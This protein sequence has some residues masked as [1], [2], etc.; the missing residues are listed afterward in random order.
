MT[1]GAASRVRVY[2]A[3]IGGAWA[4]AGADL[5]TGED[6][7]RLSG[8]RRERRRAEYLAGRA[9][10][11]FALQSATGLP[12]PSH[13]LRTSVTGKP[14][15]VDGPA[16]SVSHNGPF[17]ACAVA[18]LGEIG[19][20]VQLPSPKRRTED[21]AREH[22]TAGENEWL[23][24]RPGDA[25][26][27]L[28]VLKEAYLKATG[29]GLAGGLRS[30]ECSVDG[31]TIRCRVAAGDTPALALYRIGPGFLGLAATGHRLSPARATFA[32]APEAGAMPA[33]SFIASSS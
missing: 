27:M 22:F 25:F 10:L 9:L 17:A 12:A 29:A 2:C 24:G 20:D 31:P 26:Y 13:R 11:R 14:E 18:P 1:S 5:L 19:I 23:R 16:V 7:A 33:I 28:W 32:G 6:L 8:L 3:E 30:L 4:R 21:I 15:C